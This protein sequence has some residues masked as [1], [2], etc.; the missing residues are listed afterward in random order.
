[1]K[2]RATGLSGG[3]IDRYS[4]LDEHHRNVVTHRIDV[5][6]I[7]PYEAFGQLLFDDLPTAVLHGAAANTGVHLFENAAVCGADR[8][9]VIR[10]DENLE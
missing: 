3:L 1:M 8:C 7:G 5:L 4:F 10:T 9:L 6:A 2:R